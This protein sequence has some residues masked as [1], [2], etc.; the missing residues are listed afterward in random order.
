MCHGCFSG[1]AK[2][3]LA[4]GLVP[5]GPG[6]GNALRNATCSCRKTS[7][8]PTPPPPH[9]N[10]PKKNSLSF[11]NSK[12]AMNTETHPR[13]SS[14]PPKVIQGFLGR[15]QGKQGEAAPPAPAPGLRPGKATQGAARAEG[16]KPALQGGTWSRSSPGRRRRRC[17]GARGCR[18]GAPS[19]SPLAV[20]SLAAVAA[21]TVFK[22]PSLELSSSEHAQ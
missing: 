4:K 11:S 6:S 15:R 19:R 16:A 3:P 1:E 10:S 22:F 2:F 9:T 14:P 7:P 20:R 5:A 17:R 8:I 12:P 18:R 21:R 13:L